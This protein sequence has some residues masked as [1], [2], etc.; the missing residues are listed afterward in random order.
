[1][2]Q[3]NLSGSEA[4]SAAF[5][6]FNKTLNTYSGEALP[7]N[8]EV[9]QIQALGSNQLRPVGSRVTCWFKVASL[10]RFCCFVKHAAV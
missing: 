10:V 4:S 8:T 5:Y 1:M 6:S 7:R 3:C 2:Q 9:N